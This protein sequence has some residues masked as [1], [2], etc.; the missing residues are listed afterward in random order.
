MKKIEGPLK[1]LLGR[2]DLTDPMVGWRA[3]EIW[4]EVVGERVAANARA[5]SV[6][7]GVLMVEVESAAWMNE[8]AYLR[9]RIA[10]DLN[11]RL[12]DEV[13]KSIRLVPA[14]NP[15]GKPPSAG[16]RVQDGG[17]PGLPRGRKKQPEEP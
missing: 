8:L 16:T 1:D 15:G 7:D 2:L 13:V 5:V 10:Q 12:G 14:S 6:R 3:V 11:A 4:P 9:A 17:A